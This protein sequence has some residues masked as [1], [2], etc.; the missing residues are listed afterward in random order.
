MLLSLIMYLLLFWV[1]RL[2]LV[3]VTQVSKWNQNQV[4]ELTESCSQSSVEIPIQEQDQA[5]HQMSP[6]TE[7]A[8]WKRTTAPPPQ[9]PELT[10][11]HS[12]QVQL[13]LKLTTPPYSVNPTMENALSVQTELYAIPY[14]NIPELCTCRDESLLCVGLSP[15]QKL[16]RVPVPK[17]SIYK[18]VLTPL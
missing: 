17:P 4:Q 6:T 15:M 11:P 9:H 12:D 10:P 13:G 16:H 18:M 3:Q 5:Q 2:L 1:T 8:A 7:C 14:T